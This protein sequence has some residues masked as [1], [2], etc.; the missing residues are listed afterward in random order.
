MFEAAHELSIHDVLLLVSSDIIIFDEVIDAL[1]HLKKLGSFMGGV[2][3]HNTN[4]T[5]LI[6]FNTDW[7]S[8]VKSNM[9]LGHPGAGDF[10]LF[11]KG[12]W[13]RGIPDFTIGRSVADNW[14]IHEA[15]TFGQCVDMS[16]YM[17]IVHQNHDYSH[18]PY[19]GNLQSLINGE[20]RRD[21]LELGQ[22]CLRDDNEIRFANWNLT[23]EGVK[24]RR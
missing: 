2:H 21:N 11:S 13:R 22:V 19:G 15:I 12:F 8:M 7:V 4:I 9:L 18:I 20:E 23:K 1:P 24:R 3:R 10:F 6:D 14:L 17:N 5:E 16:D